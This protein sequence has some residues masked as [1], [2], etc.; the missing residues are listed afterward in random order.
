MSKP[1]ISVKS[2][3]KKPYS[4]YG[5]DV[6][7]KKYG[8]GSEESR[9]SLPLLEIGYA[10]TPARLDRDHAYVEILASEGGQDV[11]GELVASGNLQQR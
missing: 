11:Q 6:L 4:A 9:S 7:M 5:L 1:M 8:I 3:L 2:S 10:E